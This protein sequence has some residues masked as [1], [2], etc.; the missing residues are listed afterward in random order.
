MKLVN[1]V[2]GGNGSCGVLAGDSVVDIVS[3]WAGPNPPVCCEDVLHRGADCLERI[4]SLAATGSVRC[5]IESVRLGAPLSRPGK[6]I[7]LAGNYS[8][9]IKESPKE[10]GLSVCGESRSVPAVF[11]MPATVI[12]GPGDEIPWCVFSRQIDYEIELAAVIGKRAKGVR[13]EEA[14]DY[15]G[16]YTIANDISARSA[17]FGPGREPKRWDEFH[18]WMK[19]KWSDGF[20]P[21]GPYLVTADEVKDVQDMEMEL[22]VNGQ[23]RQKANTGQMIFPLAQQI[24]FISHI[25]T[26]EP[27]DI[28]ATGTPA[29]VGI[30]TGG[31]LQA[32]D[33][34]EASIEG[35]G[36]LVNTMGP[37]PEEFY[38]PLG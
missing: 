6:I 31:L 2:R 23:T 35:L 3:N 9:H 11:L 16:G 1:Y 22:K 5:S 8:E 17:D 7:G 32:G 36:T 38:Q 30:A 26:L 28:I 19:G 21:L 29:G 4:R 33:R 27:G 34:I 25:M 18:D 10:L 13:P 15:V 24:S 20:L 12:R 14:P 37:E